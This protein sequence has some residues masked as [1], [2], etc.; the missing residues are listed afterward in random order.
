MWKMFNPNPKGKQVGDCTV[1]AISKVLDLEWGEAYL[2]LC[3]Y[4][5]RLC[6]MPTSNNVWLWI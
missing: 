6:D 5:L 3:L 1:R 2:D 4:G